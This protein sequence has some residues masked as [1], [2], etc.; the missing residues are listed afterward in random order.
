[1]TDDNAQLFRQL[2]ALARNA[3]GRALRRAVR[4]G[5]TP[6]LERARNLIP[7]G[8][9]SHALENGGREVA[10]GFAKK[11]IRA[12]VKVSR[13]KS[14]AEAILGVRLAARYAVDFVEL[15]TS[16]TPAQPWLRPAYDQTRQQMQE[17]MAQSLRETIAAAAST[18]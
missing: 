2:R 17:A 7:V 10:P 14:K 11:N 12:I 4:A 13:D 6:A 18:P 15:G 1:M 8:V 5:I 16:K 3:Q 9:D